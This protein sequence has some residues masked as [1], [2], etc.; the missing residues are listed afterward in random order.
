M[1][2]YQ[3][4]DKQPLLYQVIVEMVT[5]HGKRILVED[6]ER[7]KIRQVRNLNKKIT[8]LK[9]VIYYKGLRYEKD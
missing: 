7:L 5:I 1:Y 9:K 4:L 3:V 8:S 2:Y 6:W